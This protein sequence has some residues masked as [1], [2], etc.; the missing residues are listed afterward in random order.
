MNF[1]SLRS[2]FAALLVATSLPLQVSADSNVNVP[3]ALRLA[4]EAFTDGI[5]GDRNTHYELDEGRIHA[6]FFNNLF[7]IGS[8]NLMSGTAI[9]RYETKVI[10]NTVTRV[11][12][13]NVTYGTGVFR[14]TDVVA[15]TYERGT[16]VFTST[17]TGEFESVL[18]GYTSGTTTTTNLGAVDINGERSIGQPA[19]WAARARADYLQGLDPNLSRPDAMTQATEDLKPCLTGSCSVKIGTLN[20][21]YITEGNTGL[22]CDS[23]STCTA[24]FTIT[25]SYDESLSRGAGNSNSK[26]DLKPTFSAT[27]TTNEGGE[28]I[29]ENRPIYE[30][31]EETETVTVYEQEEITDERPCEGEECET[32]TEEEETVV[33]ERAK[34]EWQ[35]SFAPVV[36]LQSEYTKLV[37]NQAG[38]M[39]D[40]RKSIQQESIVESFYN[41]Q[42]GNDVRPC[43]EE[44]R[45][46]QQAQYQQDTRQRTQQQFPDFPLYIDNCGPY[47]VKKHFDITAGA[48][49]AMSANYT[50]AGLLSAVTPSVTLLATL[51]GGAYSIRTVDTY[52]K[53]KKARHLRIPRDV[54]DFDKW[55]S[56]DSLQYD[57]H[58]GIVLT[59]G[60][61]FYGL[62][63]GV[64]YVAQ[65]EWKKTYIKLDDN[66]VFARLD[67]DKLMSFGMNTAAVFISLSAQK[68]I[69]WEKGV[70]FTFDISTRK[71]RELLEDFMAGRIKSVQNAAKLEGNA[72]V[73]VG[74]Q[75]KGKTHGHGASV[76]VAFPYLPMFAQWNRTEMNNETVTT[77]YNST[78]V[79][80]ESVRANVKT[81]KGQFFPFF[82]NVV[83]GFFTNVKKFTGATSRFIDKVL[84]GQYAYNFQRSYGDTKDIR[85]VLDHLKDTTG[86]FEFLDLRFPAD[87]DKVGSIDLKFGVRFKTAAT[88]HLI[89]NRNKGVLEKASNAFLEGYFNKLMLDRNSTHNICSAKTRVGLRICKRRMVK[90]TRKA[91]AKM[92]KNLNKMAAL[93]SGEGKKV[94]KSFAKAYNEF[95]Q[96][97]MDSPFAFQAALN[98]SK[99]FGSDVFLSLE[100]SKTRKH[101]AVLQFDSL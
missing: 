39:E 40:L 13:S 23:P 100:T 32:V 14:N 36:T 45:Q 46:Q 88:K 17:P 54:T 33:T 57:V 83:E 50:N 29:Y 12:P 80:Y 70:S 34:K 62:S 44:R 72:D 6:G 15:Y 9:P 49:V 53:G 1:S 91:I 7:Q 89:R 41:N 82:K 26:P 64:T 78:R 75:T 85:K 28:P 35:I 2:I 59:G 65:G 97:M 52:K 101:E 4:T 24:E 25:G 63:A 30:D 11:I 3:Y 66:T 55:R 71:G 51:G 77:H 98:V 99:G 96:A 79:E 56:N 20:G 8:F 21:V 87:L 38:N 76:G 58:G 18:V 31:V 67:K 86:L 69:T 90:R 42:N 19:S 43:V 94:R 93:V 74:F 22:T 95:G 81:F 68:F 10:T 84:G 73:L 60:V 27:E 37:L 5:R 48:G 16:G 92:V 61:G 47:V